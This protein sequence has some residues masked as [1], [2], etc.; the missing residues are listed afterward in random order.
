[1]DE[2]TSHLD[3]ESASRIYE[4]SRELTSKGVTILNITHDKRFLEYSDYIVDLNKCVHNGE[5]R[6]PESCTQA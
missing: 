1:M 6:T 2:V 4:I 5:E 3:S